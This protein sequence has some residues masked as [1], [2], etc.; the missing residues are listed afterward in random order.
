LSSL[1][2][3][4]FHKYKIEIITHTR[5]CL[6]E[7]RQKGVNGKRWVREEKERK[8]KEKE[9]LS[10]Q[11]LDPAPPMVFSHQYKANDSHSPYKLHE[12]SISLIRH[13]HCCW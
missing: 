5:F 11:P 13:G 12:Q 9:R 10:P 2:L 1:Q 3:L 8:G 4:N 6:V 7:M